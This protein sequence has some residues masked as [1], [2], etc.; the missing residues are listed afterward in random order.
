MTINVEHRPVEQGPLLG[1]QAKPGVRDAVHVAVAAV[2]AIVAVRPGAHVGL[3]ASDRSDVVSPY[4]A[5][6]IGIVDPFLGGDVPRGQVFWLCL[7]PGSVTSL[8]HVYDHPALAAA[9]A[10]RRQQVEEAARLLEPPVLPPEPSAPLPAPLPEPLP[11]PLRRSFA[12]AARDNIF[13][14]RYSARHEMIDGECYIRIFE[15]SG[16]RVLRRDAFWGLFVPVVL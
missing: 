13:G 12:V 4:V 10:L 14:L 1:N 8:R 7:Y 16:S 15:G 11:E 6:T 5:D 2:T 9:A 3:A